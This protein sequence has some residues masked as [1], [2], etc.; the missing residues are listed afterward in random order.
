MTLNCLLRTQNICHQSQPV[1]VH[2]ILITLPNEFIIIT[3]D[4]DEHKISNSHNMYRYTKH[5]RKMKLNKIIR[6]KNL[7]IENIQ[8]P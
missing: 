3:P 7:I 8:L 1:M 5:Y 2:K 4:K 6:N